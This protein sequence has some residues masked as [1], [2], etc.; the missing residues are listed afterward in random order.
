MKIILKRAVLITG[1]LLCISCLTVQPGDAE[2]KKATMPEIEAKSPRPPAVYAGSKSCRECHEKF[3]TLWSTSMHGLAMQPYTDILGKEKLTLHK[4]DIS[5]GNFNYRAEIGPGNGYVLEIG[6]DGNKTEYPMA[7]A[8]G[9]KNVYYFLT[10]MDRGYLQT[11]PLA[12]DVKKKEWFDTAGSGVRHFPGSQLMDH[13]VDWKERPYT[14]NASCHGCHVSQITSNYDI[15]SDSYDTHWTEPG[16]NCETCHGPCSQ[17]NQAMR[18][19]AAGKKTPDKIISPKNFTPVQH[20]DTCNSCHARILPLTDGY[21]TPER[22]FDHF[23]LVTLESHDFY[24][25]GRDLGENYTLASWLQSPCA[26]N[27]KLTCLTCHTSSGRYRFDKPED[28]NK[29][30]SPCHQENVDHVAS[31]SHHPPESIAGRC[32]SCHMPKTEF[33]RMIRSDHSMRP[34]TP[35]TTIAFHSPNA[36]NGCHVDKDADW[37]DQQ[38]RQWSQHDF[39]APVLKR[40]SLVDAARKNDWSQLTEILAYID[41]PKHEEIIAA[42]LIR[43]LAQCPD[44]RKTPVLR[45]SLHDPSPLIRASAVEI[46]GYAWNMERDILQDLIA[47]TADDYRVVR[48]RAAAALAARPNLEIY[49]KT[50]ASV[51]KAIEEYLFSLTAR[52]DSWDGHYNLGNYYQ[53]NG[54]PQEALAEYELASKFEPR[55]I[56]PL[57]NA[58][59]VHASLG[60]MTKTEV[61]LNQALSIAPDNA[62]IHYNLGLLLAE[63]NRL[64]DAEAHLRSALAANPQLAGAAYNL[65]IVLSNDNLDEAIRLGRIAVELRPDVLRY[66]QSLA[67]FLQRNG[68]KDE[69][70]RVLKTTIERN[71]TN[72][73]LQ[74]LLQKIS[75]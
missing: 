16:I 51:N 35:A 71:P 15:R 22:F 26:K 6:P 63:Q 48:V 9:G 23:D 73:E 44:P 30:C 45:K 17:H 46:L 4:E 66:A 61:K 13:P 12:Y 32:V 70:I 36:C 43:L 25:D 65:S 8:L 11:L 58:A 37:A 47:A 24:P 2:T 50:T 53:K 27:S 64:P 49:G 69:A 74:A 5:I 59:L 19:L 41:D 39:Q 7:Y 60:E 29:A 52:P 40:A 38:V 14:F 72:S 68:D 34:P 62:A 1:I 18:D 28:A 33:A 31:H 10:P 42:G 75:K 54:Q 21:R 56:Q 20:N 67:I 57:V 55:A 3:Y